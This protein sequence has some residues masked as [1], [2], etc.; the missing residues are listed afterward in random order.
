MSDASQPT[1]Q[2]SRRGCP[3]GAQHNLEVAEVDLL[4]PLTIRGVTLR[5]RI[6][7]SPMCQYCAHEGFADD[8]HLVHLGSRAVG[9][10]ALVFVEATAVVRDG[11][12]TAGDMGLWDDD[13]TEPLARIARFVQSQGA[14]PGIQLA[15]AGRK[16]SCDVPWK[17]GAR[18]KTPAEGGWTVVAPSP[19]PFNASDPVP[20]A[21][22]PAGIESILAAFEAAARRALEAGFR[23]LEIHAAHGYLLHEFLSPLSNHRN[24][25]YGG[26]LDNR[27]RLL[28]R[29]A[30]TVRKLMPDELPLFVRISGTDWVDGGWDIEQSVVLACRLKELGVDLID[31]SSGGIVPVAQIPVGKGYQVPLASRIRGDSAIMTGAVGLITD[32]EFADQIITSGDADLV[33]IGREMLREPYWALKAQQALGGEQSWPIPYGYAVKRRSK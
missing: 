9:G 8:W 19:I 2:P 33:L 7:V 11:R 4:S 17:G 24:D 28:L 22:D 13:H 6:A 26:S 16:A 30:E 23:V 12:I 27:M 14:V 1:I 31:V 20:V 25:E 5:N 18:L 15:H 10:A 3:T 21:L 32:P 29:V